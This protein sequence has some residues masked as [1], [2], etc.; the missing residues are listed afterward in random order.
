MTFEFF[1]PEFVHFGAAEDVNS[2][3]EALLLKPVA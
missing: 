2:L 1:G 3:R